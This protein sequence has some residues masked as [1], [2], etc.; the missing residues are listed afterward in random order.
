MARVKGSPHKAELDGMKFNRLLVIKRIGGSLWECLCDCGVGILTTT[1]Q[2]KSGKTKSCGCYSKDR[3]TKHGM[4]GTPTYNTWGHMLS[5]CR[6]ET[7]KQYADY[8]G[9]GIAVCKEWERFEVFFADMGEKPEGMSLDRIDNDLGYYKDNCRWAD[10]KT[11]VRNRRNSP[12]VIWE[13]VEVSLAK[14]CE[15]KGVKWRMVYE[16]IRAG[17]AVEKAINTPT[18]K[19][20]KNAAPL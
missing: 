7:H 6:S 19:K 8:G 20:E 15:T 5:R 2:L 13:G 12:V 9:R 11:Q 16:R 18:R 4:E 3:M 14:L 10:Q 17:W 1:Y